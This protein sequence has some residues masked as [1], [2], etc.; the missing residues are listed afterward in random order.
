VRHRFRVSAEPTCSPAARRSASF[1]DAA[2]RAR[3]AAVRSAAG[4]AR[5]GARRRCRRPAG[6]ERQTRAGTPGVDRAA[7]TLIA[8][9]R[10][11]AMRRSKRGPRPETDA[12]TL[13]LRSPGP[14]LSQPGAH[15]HAQRA[16]RSRTP[17][18]TR[19][20]PLPE[21]S[22]KLSG[23]R[24][25]ARCS[26]G[27]SRRRPAAARILVSDGSIRTGEWVRRRAGAA[28]TSTPSGS[29]TP[30]CCARSR[31]SRRASPP[32]TRACTS[33]TPR[34]SGAVFRSTARCRSAAACTVAS[35]PTSRSRC[36][37]GRSSAVRNR[38]SGV[39]RGSGPIWRSSATSRRTN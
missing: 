11:F 38:R 17:A 1:R 24:A 19:G 8:G 18:R 33:R 31:H 22:I 37:A 27:R 29:S 34:D 32:P 6:S 26:R 14:S 35:T 9:W 7:A 15:V 25:I 12:W 23:L 28:S 36:R 3:C 5:H 16:S 10:A 30:S 2:T 21:L 20:R 39:A 4:A 13:P